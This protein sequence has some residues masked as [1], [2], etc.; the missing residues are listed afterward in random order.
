MKGLGGPTDDVEVVSVRVHGW[1][2]GCVC[3]PVCE[4]E[5]AVGKWLSGPRMIRRLCV[6]TPRVCVFMF[7]VCK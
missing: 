5:L 7:H 3:V 2:V 1:M 4:C 6:N